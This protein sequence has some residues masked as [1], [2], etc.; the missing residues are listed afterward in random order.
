M[1]RLHSISETSGTDGRRRE[2][3]VLNRM[4]VTTVGLLVAAVIAM[5]MACQTVKSPAHGASTP[6]ATQPYVSP[7]T[8]ATWVSPIDGATMVY[9]PAGEFVMGAS[10]SDPEAQP[11]EHPQHKVYLEAFWIDATEVTNAQFARFV[12]ATGYQTEGERAG[13][14]RFFETITRKWRESSRVNWR[15]PHGLFSS[16]KGLE[17]HPV[18]HIS[19][20]DAQ[21]YCAWAGKRLP[22]EAEWEKAARGTDGRLYPW[23]NSRPAGELLNF[24]D[25]RLPVPWADQ[26]VDDGYRFTAPVG[27]YPAGASPYGALDMAGNVWE[28]VADWYDEAYYAGSPASDPPGPPS[29]TSHVLRGGSWYDDAGGVR[30]TDRAAWPYL[31]NVT[32]AVV[33]FRCARSP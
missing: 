25:R 2:V 15:H 13:T 7:H 9:V 18:V 20:N 17:A 19:W 32:S 26:A 30:S 5:P 24:A 31:P 11:D 12:Q 22:T 6:P 28:W 29:G 16:L 27:S 14:G 3:S 10:A 33:G 21:A 23:G 4:S 1:N 8:S